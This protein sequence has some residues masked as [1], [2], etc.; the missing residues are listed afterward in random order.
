[1][2]CLNKQVPGSPPQACHYPP[3]RSGKNMVVICLAFL[4][5]ILLVQFAPDLP[6]A[7]WGLP[8]LAVI[9][10]SL[11]MR[12]RFLAAGLAG[13]LWAWWYAA[14]LLAAS[15]P[16][17][18][19]GVDLWLEGRIDGLVQ[20]RGSSGWRIPLQVMAWQE[21]GEWQAFPLRIQLNWYRPGARPEPGETWR[22]KVRLKRP[23]GYA[24]PGSFD[25]ERWLFRQGIRATGYVRDDPGNGP[26]TEARGQGIDR[27]RRH[28]QQTLSPLTEGSRTGPLLEALTIGVRDGLD[29]EHWQVLRHTGTSHL[30]AISGLHVGLVSGLLFWLARRLWAAWG[31]CARWP[32]PVVASWAGLAGALFYGVLAGFSIPTRRA[33]LMVGVVLLALLWRRGLRPG[34]SLCLALLAVLALDP[35]SVLDAGFWLSF[36]AV[37][38]LVL[39]LSGQ[40]GQGYWIGLLKMQWVLGLGMFP[41]VLGLFQEASLI[42]PLTNLVAVPWV[43]LVVVPMALSAALL[44]L[45][46]PALAM[47]LWRLADHLMQPLWHLLELGGGWPFSSWHHHLPGFALLAWGLPGLLL[48]IAARRWSLRLL[49]I[50]LLLPLVLAPGPAPPPGGA[51][52][53]LLDVG[54]G[55]AAVVRTHRHLLVY[56]TGPRYPS[57][58]NTG[59]AVLAPVLRGQGIRAVDRL[60]ISHG[61]NDHAGGAEALY[62][63]LPVYGIRSPDPASIRWA[64]SRRCM[65][66]ER[67]TWDGVEFSFLL[68]DSEGLRGN[69]SSCVLRVRAG[70]H[71]LLLPG[72]IEA[73]SERRL[74]TGGEALEARVLVA[75]HHG[76]LSSSTPAFIDAVRPQWVLFP[77]GYRNRWNFPRPEIVQ[78]YGERGVSQLDTARHGAIL[79]RLEPGRAVAPQTHRQQRRRY[80]QSPL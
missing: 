16:V 53:S 2:D 78:R 10:I 41:L 59:D 72:D 15:L 28:L 69:D 42:A 65:R 48:L 76:S 43:G 36:A 73:A 50:L 52:F 14:W 3:N 80:W 29:E 51:W 27:L 34:Q 33:V 74:L 44:A 4:A 5:G 1:M 6:A 8:L 68:P 38:L 21:E 22:F 37:A 60:V 32:A 13:A 61:D 12:W 62:A 11:H 25:Y 49:G 45:L 57:G 71:V 19:E 7:G 35:L 30:M 9:A 47:P 64:Y 31:D 55:L 77:V 18:R 56:D 75:P 17:D 26:V 23:R 79:L 39:F 40:E 46:S 70:E 20:D 67:W 63:Q 66:G 24:N 58:F 54:Q